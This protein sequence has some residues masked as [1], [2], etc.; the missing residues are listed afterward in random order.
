MTTAYKVTGFYGSTAI[1]MIMTDTA[2]A[3]WRKD[4]LMRI[5]NVVPSDIHITYRT[6]DGCERCT[7]DAYVPHYN[8]IYNGK[9]PG[10]TLGHCTANAC[11]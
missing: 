8:C 10:H 7:T 2:L 3:E 9:A 11:Y 1:D 5:D 6:A 4:A